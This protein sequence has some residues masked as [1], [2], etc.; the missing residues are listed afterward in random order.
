[1]VNLGVGGASAPSSFYISSLHHLPAPLF[2]LK[3]IF[4]L[5]FTNVK[6]PMPIIHYQGYLSRE[7]GARQHKVKLRTMN[8]WLN[9]NLAA[10]KKVSYIKVD[11]NIYIKDKTSQAAPP[12]GIQLSTLEWVPKFGERNK[13][14]FPLIYEQIIAGKV[15]G[16]FLVD[17][18]FVINTEPA[19]L[20]L[21]KA[22]KL[23][24]R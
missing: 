20:A 17:R 18:V 4:L 22:P 11:G 19:L 5:C 9:R 21:I 16:V 10:E 8:D 15:S 1:M 7:D 14:W 12:T 2:F 6:S 24:R 13:V 3:N 23:D